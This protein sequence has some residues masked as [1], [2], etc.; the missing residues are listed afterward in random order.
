MANYIFVFDGI[1]VKEGQTSDVIDQAARRLKAS[2]AEHGQDFN[3]EWVD[4]P[5]SMAGIG[6]YTWSQS[7]EIAIK[8][9]R[10][11]LANLEAADKF[12]ILA[13][14][15]GNRPVHEWLE[16]TAESAPRD[17]D[18]VLA[19]GFASDPYRPY[20]KQQSGMPMP[21]GYGVCGQKEGPIPDRSFWVANPWDVITDAD[22]DSMLRTPADLSDEFP[23]DLLRGLKRIAR[24]GDF[25]LA[26]NLKLFHE[27]PLRWFTGLG[28]RLDRARDGIIGY[29][30]GEHTTAYTRSFDGG[31]S[32]M[33]RFGNTIS[34]KV[35]N[36]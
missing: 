23:G 32:P 28:A 29:A 12:V 16:R 26:R 4:W 7:T 31:D 21:S 3:V 22:D 19:V 6:K 36:P 24:T 2:L 33:V 34:W 8:N 14:S 1:G 5:A 10:R 27:N 15:G 9:F 20:G 18:R 17:L 25:Q 35:R 13:F 30:T 11:R